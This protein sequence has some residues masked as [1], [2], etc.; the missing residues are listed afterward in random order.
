MKR[1]ETGLRLKDV[2][3][4]HLQYDQ[5]RSKGG[6]NARDAILRQ[7]TDTR[8]SFLADAGQLLEK[9]NL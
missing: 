8:E 2:Q 3:R 7:P 4:L 6:F 1:V 5:V 9:A